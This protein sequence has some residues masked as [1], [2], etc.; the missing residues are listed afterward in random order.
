MNETN[1][2]MM[3]FIMFIVGGCCI[4]MG[5]GMM[6]GFNPFNIMMGYGAGVAFTSYGFKY[7]GDK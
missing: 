1:R 3:G 2:L 6:V 4:I 5:L 7:F